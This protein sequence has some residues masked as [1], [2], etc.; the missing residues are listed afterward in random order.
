M[1][2]NLDSLGKL[3]LV[4]MV[5]LLQESLNEKERTIQDLDA[6]C[7]NLIKENQ[8]LTK[9]TVALK[10]AL[11]DYKESCS[12]YYEKLEELNHSKTIPCPAVIKLNEP[13]PY[14]T[15]GEDHA[16]NQPAVI[17]ITCPSWDEW[18]S[19]M[20]NGNGWIG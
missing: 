17:N 16:K 14:Y 19:F 2:S 11:L 18:E 1:S 3:T 12:F 6:V 20:D 5:R 4:Y 15:I 13:S 8:S 9:E 7:Y 10:D